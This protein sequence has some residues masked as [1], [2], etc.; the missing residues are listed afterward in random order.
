[1][2]PCRYTSTEV[3]LSLDVILARS[4]SIAGLLSAENTSILRR[5]PIRLKEKD[6]SEKL[7]IAWHRSWWVVLTMVSLPPDRKSTEEPHWK[8]IWAYTNFSL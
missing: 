4:Y 3:L 6:A 2:R 7:R 1:M 5:R 8:I